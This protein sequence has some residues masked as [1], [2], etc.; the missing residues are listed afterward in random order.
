MSSL[1]EVIQWIDSISV[2][3]IYLLCMVL[4]IRRKTMY[5]VSFVFIHLSWWYSI[6]KHSPLNRKR[7]ICSCFRIHSVAGPNS[8]AKFNY[9]L[10][11]M[12]V[13]GNFLNAVSTILN[14][15]ITLIYTLLMS[16]LNYCLTLRNIFQ[17]LL[18]FKKDEYKYKYAHRC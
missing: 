2:E 18:E 5:T 9:V 6:W 17:Y 15:I 14:I 10:S 3:W 4:N 7:S 13:S 11:E 12:A 1:G 16:L 8:F